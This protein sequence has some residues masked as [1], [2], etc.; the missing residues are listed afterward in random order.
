MNAF[1]VGDIVRLK[2]ALE[3]LMTVNS[4]TE[5]DFGHSTV[6]VIECIWFEKNKKHVDTF[7]PE[8]LIKV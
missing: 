2:S 7:K 8:V 3:P 6:P 1:V 5:K 4:I